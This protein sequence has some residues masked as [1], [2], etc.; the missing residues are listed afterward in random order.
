MKTAIVFASKHGTTAKVAH[1]IKNGL[2]YQNTDIYNLKVASKI[3]VDKY[4]CVIIGGSIHAGRVQSSLK[5]FCN[6]NHSILK[7]KHLGLFICCMD[8][9]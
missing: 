1:L 6:K 4:D 5:K 2:E 3:D 9:T 7:S 8:D